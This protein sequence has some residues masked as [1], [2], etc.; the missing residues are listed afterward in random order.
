[1][2]K[3]RT[4][5][6]LAAVIALAS[7]SSNDA[8]E[9]VDTPDVPISL[10]C[11]LVM[12]TRAYATTQATQIA[13]GRTIS[14]WC[15]EHVDKTDATNHATDVADYVKA[16][17]LTVDNST[18]SGTLTS[19][20]TYI[21]PKTGNNVDFYALHGNFNNAVTEGTATWATFT[22]SLT[23][24]VRTNQTGVA[25][26]A[27]EDYADGYEQS[28][29]LYAVKHNIAKTK[30]TQLLQFKHLMSKIEVYL[31]CGT[32]ITQ[33]DIQ[34]ANLKVE[35]INTKLTAN[36][37]LSKAAPMSST[38][39]AA[40]TV[41]PTTLNAISTKQ[42]TS[43]T[44]MVTVPDPV[45]PGSTTSVNAYAFAE[46]IIVPQQFDTNYDGTGTGMSLIRLTMGDNSERT[47]TPATYNFQPGKRYVFY[48]TVNQRGIT[49]TGE[50]TDWAAGTTSDVVAM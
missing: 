33:A 3:V 44:E 23:H 10:S 25:A 16:W 1:M 43:N 22:S 14:V 30:T 13:H 29:L 45:N 28:D 38:I 24:T 42:Q 20:N 36:L 8:P 17:Q 49:I 34:H 35:I 26:T 32:G 46:A 11:S 4:Y 47:T 19:A 2:Y 50:I 12:Q 9:V 27:P 40:G 31:S 39:T 41:N 6:T 7:C 5:I 21:Y 18:T 37:T 48:V 15:D